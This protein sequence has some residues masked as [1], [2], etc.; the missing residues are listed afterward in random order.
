MLVLVL[1]VLEDIG[2]EAETGAEARPLPLPLPR[3]FVL[4]ARFDTTADVEEFA[5]F[6]G[7]ELLPSSSSNLSSS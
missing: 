7:I 3:A 5:R 1:V 4:V 2:N 6:F